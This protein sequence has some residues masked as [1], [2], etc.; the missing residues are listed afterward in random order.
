MKKYICIALLGILAW[1]FLLR[2]ENVTL[3]PGVKV[4]EYPVQSRP[5]TRMSFRYKDYTITPLADFNITAK[6]L[7]KKR[8]RY[9]REAELS[10]VDLAL[11]WGNMSDESVLAEMKIWQSNRWYRWRVDTFPIPRNEIISHSGNMHIIPANSLIETQILSAP[12]GSI[13]EFSGCLVRVNGD[14]GWYWISSL[15]R[16]DV[17]NHSCEVVWVEEFYIR[18]M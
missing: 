7:S 16:D 15:R 8:Y 1:Y 6:V 12:E 10:P 13:V 17:G 4:P 3:G 14:D 2:E 11:G 9:G 5:S 18:E